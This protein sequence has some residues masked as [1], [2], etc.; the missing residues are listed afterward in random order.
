MIKLVKRFLFFVAIF[1]W[2]ISLITHLLSIFDIDFSEAFPLE[3]Y[4]SLGIF[5]IWALA[6]AL[7]YEKDDSEHQL[8]EEENNFSKTLSKIP[9]WLQVILVLSCVYAI[10][11][12]WLTA[13]GYSAEVYNGKYILMEKGTFI[14]NLTKTEYTN[15]IANNTRLSTGHCLAFYA[16]GAA[17]L[18]NYKT[19]QQG[20]LSKFSYSQH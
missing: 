17:F 13:N 19:K 11:N 6:I 10:I 9:K 5:A 7:S 3:N 14:R 16:L 1:C 2:I 12:F 15:Y 8:I 4:L 18:Y 20:T